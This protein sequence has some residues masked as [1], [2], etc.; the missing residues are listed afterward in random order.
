MIVSTRTVDRIVSSDSHIPGEKQMHG[1]GF[2]V[3]KSYLLR[4]RLFSLLG[5]QSAGWDPELPFSL[6]DL[7]VVAR[8]PLAPSS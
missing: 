4:A 6:Q 2:V 8:G 7:D 3:Q 5:L 1:L